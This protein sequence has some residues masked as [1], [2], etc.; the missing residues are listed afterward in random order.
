MDWIPLSV[1]IIPQ[2]LVDKDAERKK[3]SL[4]K[5]LRSTRQVADKEHHTHLFLPHGELMKMNPCEYPQFV[6]SLGLVFLRETRQYLHVNVTSVPDASRMQE[7]I[8]SYVGLD[9]PAWVT[10]RQSVVALKFPIG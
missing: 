8:A 1:L 5:L 4:D 9:N 3:A 2:K 7:F 10:K 6:L